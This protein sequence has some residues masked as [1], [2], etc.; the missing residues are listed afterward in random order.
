MKIENYNARSYPTQTGT[1][2]LLAV[3]TSAPD[4]YKVYAGIIPDV[5]L[6]PEGYRPYLDWIVHNGAPLRHNEAVL[7]FPTLS[8]SEYRA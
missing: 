6:E 2:I 4:G 3:L 1:M 8:K 5:S 7:N